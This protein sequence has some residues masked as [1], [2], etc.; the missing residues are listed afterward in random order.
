MFFSSLKTLFKVLV[1]TSLC[2][3][4]LSFARTYRYAVMGDAGEWNSNT[5]KVYSSLLRHNVKT[6]VMP[7]DNLYSW[8]WSAK[9]YE[10]VWYPW[11]IANFDF[12]A[13]AIGNHHGG[14][15]EEVKYFEMP[16]EYYAKIINNF[17]KFIVLNSDNEA[18]AAYQA[19]FLEYAL[20]NAQT[21]FTFIVYHHPTYTVSPWHWDI[22]KAKFQ[23]A[24]RPILHK[25]RNKITAL[26]VGHDHISLV[27]HYNDLPVILSGSTHEQRPHLPLNYTNDEVTVTTNWYNSTH[28]LWAYL[29]LDDNSQEA[30]VNYIRGSNDKP[31]CTLAIVTGQKARFGSNCFNTSDTGSI[32]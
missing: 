24:I 27:A 29:T 30:R 32:D 31:M 28:A 22:E 20:L 15:A 1:F 3:C 5:R 26:L 25:Y 16:S 2:V 6:L 9:T 10:E 19:Q 7:G 13:V 8:P 12:L 4:N 23:K 21:P 17:V 18:N 14:Y 11:R